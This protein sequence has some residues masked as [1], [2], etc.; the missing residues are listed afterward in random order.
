MAKKAKKQ[1]K[2]KGQ[3]ELPIPVERTPVPAAL[4]NGLRE[5]GT[6]K[7]R[8]STKQIKWINDMLDGKVL[9]ASSVFGAA[10]A[11]LS[12]KQK[13]KFVQG[14]RDQLPE[15]SY[16]GINQMIAALKACPAKSPSG[17]ETLRPEPRVQGA[18]PQVGAKVEYHNVTTDQG[19]KRMGR[20]VLPNGKKVL[21]GSYGLK[22]KK[23][24]FANDVS[25]FKVWIG[26]RGGWNVKLY[27]SD[28]TNRV[29][30]TPATQLELLEKIAK[31]PQK[32]AARFGW[33]FKRCG[34]C[35]RGLTKDESRERGIGPV[36]AE[37]L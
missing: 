9:E 32:A 13:D 14:L 28:D 15:M 21:A 2:L 4:N 23:M 10:L 37:R 19:T 5:D 25:F 20:I 26:D 12:P 8:G 30:L 16:D 33:E 35:G 6:R 36:C 17:G 7:D 3:Q 31:N 29:M 34:I 22:T 11:D 24:G 18:H 27:V 1:K